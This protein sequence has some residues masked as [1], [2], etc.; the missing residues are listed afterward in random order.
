M[1]IALVAALLLAVP[2]SALAARAESLH[3]LRSAEAAFYRAQ[4]PFQADWTPSPANPYLRPTALNDPRRGVPKTLSRHLTGW[5]EGVNSSTFK[6][7]TVFVFDQGAQA[8]SYARWWKTRCKAPNCNGV[9][10]RANN[11]FYF[12]ARFPAASRAMAQLRSG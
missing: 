1:R 2:G 9:A 10:L 7:W 12:G 6:S 8:A 4:L 3:S 11:V 5:A